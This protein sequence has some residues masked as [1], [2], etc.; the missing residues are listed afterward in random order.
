MEGRTEFA[1]FHTSNRQL[2]I[3]H[4]NS[5]ALEEPRLVCINH[6]NIQIKNDL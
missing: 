1:V 4:D 2:I 5:I 6:I 3:Y